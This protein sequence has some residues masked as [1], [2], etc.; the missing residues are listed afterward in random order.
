MDTYLLTWN[1]KAW[2]WDDLSDVLALARRGETIE[3]RWSCGNTT[4]IPVGARAFLLRQSVEPKGLLAS[5]WVT[6]GTY[7]DRHWNPTKASAG[8]TANFV[9]VRF[10]TVLDPETEQLLDPGKFTSRSLAR[11]NWK[12]QASGSRVLAESAAELENVWSAHIGRTAARR[13]PPV[14]ELGAA[15]EGI[16]SVRLRLHRSRERSLRAAKL[17]DAAERAPDGRLRCEVPGCGFDFFERYGHIGRGFAHVHHVLPLAESDGGVQTRL[18]DLAVVCANCHAMIH[19]G[20]ESRPLVGLIPSSHA[21]K[22]EEAS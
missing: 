8:I 3:R 12:P 10:D 1:P 14:S 17:A 6:R 7:Q 20:R 5:G 19:R 9:R 15:T 4:S 21:K 22:A 11:V 2:S 16:I 13:D 18:N